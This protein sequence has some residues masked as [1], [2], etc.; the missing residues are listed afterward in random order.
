MGI[1]CLTISQGFLGGL[2]FG[3]VFENWKKLFEKL[4]VLNNEQQ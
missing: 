2:F 4:E 3:T 1:K